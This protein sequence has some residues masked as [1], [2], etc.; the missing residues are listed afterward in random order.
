[1]TERHG[2]PFFKCGCERQAG[3]VDRRSK[4]GRAAHSAAR[5]AIR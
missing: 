5:F 3:W 2:L 4:M 1:M